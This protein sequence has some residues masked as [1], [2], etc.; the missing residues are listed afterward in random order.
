MINLKD[1]RYI[2]IIG[3]GEYGNVHLIE[4]IETGLQYAAKEGIS[5]E[6]DSLMI[7]LQTYLKVD[8]SAILP[9]LGYSPCNFNG[10]KHP[11][12]IIKYMENGSLKEMLK[13]VR[14]SLAPL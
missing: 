4:N 1:Y 10:E 14:I 12:L 8:N 13:N 5:Y 9:F 2:K 7:E 3:K 6:N 11:M